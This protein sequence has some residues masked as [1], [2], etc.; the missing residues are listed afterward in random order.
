[1]AVMLVEVRAVAKKGSEKL[2]EYGRKRNRVLAVGAFS[3]MIRRHSLITGSSAAAI[4]I[5]S[6]GF[7]TGRG[8]CAS[9]F[10]KSG[11]W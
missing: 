5:L 2:C 3:A 4:F 11:G 10:Q 8:F 1:M 7:Q 9:G 6:G